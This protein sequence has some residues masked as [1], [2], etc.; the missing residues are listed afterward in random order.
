MVFGT[1]GMSMQ[2][3]YIDRKEFN[4]KFIY[5][6]IPF[7]QLTKKLFFESFSIFR[8]YNFTKIKDN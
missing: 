4:K 6:L 3:N 2:K 5:K 8:N 1:N 7:Y